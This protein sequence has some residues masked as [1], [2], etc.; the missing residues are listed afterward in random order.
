M[1]YTLAQMVVEWK[2]RR[3]LEP[4]R[5]DATYRRQ[6]AFEID[7][8]IKREIDDWYE[9]LLSEAPLEFLVVTDITD[10]V[11]V[12]E[13]D[14][15]VATLSLPAGC[16]RL[17]ELKM[18][19]WEREAALTR[20][21]TPL[22]RRQES[23]FSRGYHVS[24]VGVVDVTGLRVRLYGFKNRLEPEPERVL[25]VMRPPEGIYRLKPGGWRV[26]D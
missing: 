2:V 12:E 13:F 9:R 21:G 15:H 10:E 24:P 17:V 14:G 5:T 19:G 8:Y 26:N 22:A 23:P 25:A 18:A 1:E 16:V 6:D 4:L 11:V 20:V 7:E 3:G